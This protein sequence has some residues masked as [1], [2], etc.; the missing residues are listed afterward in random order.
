M[1]RAQ[2]DCLMFIVRF[3]QQNNHAPSYREIAAGRGYSSAEGARVMVNKLV[4]LRYLAHDTGRGRNLRVLR[5][6]PGQG[7]PT[8]SELGWAADIIGRLLETRGKTFGAPLVADLF[9]VGDFLAA[10]ERL[11]SSIERG[12][13]E[14]VAA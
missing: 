2:R 3:I 9:K 1:T 10:Q 6:P 8:A 13:A 11:Q 7:A 12:Q 14:S 4:R 5:L